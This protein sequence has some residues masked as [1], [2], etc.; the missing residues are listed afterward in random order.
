M[1]PAPLI[2]LSESAELGIRLEPAPEVRGLWERG[3]NLVAKAADGLKNA[4]RAQTNAERIQTAKEALDRL[5]T[6]GGSERIPGE[7]PVYI[8]EKGKQS[9]KDYIK[10]LEVKDA[11]EGATSAWANYLDSAQYV[12]GQ[13]KSLFGN[14]FSS[15]EDAVVNFAMT[16]KLSFADFTKSILVDMARIAA[17]Q[18]SSV[19]LSSLVG[20]GISYF[21]GSG[22]GPTGAATAGGAEAGAQSFG[23]Q[24]DA[25][26]GNVMFP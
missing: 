26:S 22:T 23:S 19:L 21:T 16:G 8:G 6:R 3:Y 13:T 25:S 4:G 2:D 20:A 15:M 11:A 5:E 7:D 14:A 24:F 18:A 9:L 12:A 1:P 17:R 10:G